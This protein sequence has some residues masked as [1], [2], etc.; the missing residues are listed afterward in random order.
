M[1]NKK[2]SR[3]NIYT[4]N[5]P[6]IMRELIKA[7]V[8]GIITDDPKLLKYILDENISGIGGE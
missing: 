8:S 5:S 6:M 4:V 3:V 1:C 7:R 2:K